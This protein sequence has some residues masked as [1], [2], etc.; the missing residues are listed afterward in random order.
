VGTIAT[1]TDDP[2]GAANLYKA[3][4]PMAQEVV[5]E[6]SSVTRVRVRAQTGWNVHSLLDEATLNH[7][8]DEARRR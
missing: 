4:L 7:I 6:E 8:V 2:E 5:A 1:K 3:S